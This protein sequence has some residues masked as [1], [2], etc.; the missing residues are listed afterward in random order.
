MP[1][2]SR[3]HAPIYKNT[4]SVARDHLASERTFLAWTRTGLG[5]V[6]LGLAVERFSRFELDNSMRSNR[7]KDH[8]KDHDKKDHQSSKILVGVLMAMGTGTVLYATRR[9]F[10]V[11]RRLEKGEFRPA[12][13]GVTAMGAVTGTLAAGVF[14]GTANEWRREGQDIQNSP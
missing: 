8:D 7:D 11:L 9:Y 3:L 12:Y 4:G 5:F 2:W 13:H 1:P 6:A 14:A 10:A